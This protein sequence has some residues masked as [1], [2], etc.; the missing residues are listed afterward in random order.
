M[1][2][3]LN[4]YKQKLEKLNKICH[5]NHDRAPLKKLKFCQITNTTNFKL[6]CVEICNSEF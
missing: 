3:S 4:K 5:I 2:N 6:D 1:N